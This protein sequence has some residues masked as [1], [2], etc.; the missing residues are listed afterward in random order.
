MKIK[1]MF[2]L[3][4]LLI[5]VTIPIACNNGGSDKGN[6]SE[7][8]NANNPGERLDITKYLVKDKINIVDFYSEFCPPCRKISPLLSKLDKKRDDIVVIK[9]DINRKGIKGIDW[10]SPLAKQY[11]LRSIPH[12]K[13]YDGKGN[14]LSEDIVARQ[15]I[16]VYFNEEGIK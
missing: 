14:K 1:S 3:T 5:I 10:R 11:E 16:A 9:I 6:N 13:I 15:K 4:I 7:I 8:L 12:F 2:I